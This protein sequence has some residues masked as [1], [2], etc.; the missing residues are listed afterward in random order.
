M[1]VGTEHITGVVATKEAYPDDINDIVIF[2]MTPV[3]SRWT[4]IAYEYFCVHLCV[5]IENYELRKITP[6][7]ISG[8]HIMRHIPDLCHI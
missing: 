8:H 2:L 5:C 3:C 6:P 4:R 7:E 1:L